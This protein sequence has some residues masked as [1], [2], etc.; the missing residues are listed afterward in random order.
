MITI[1]ASLKD[2]PKVWL[3]LHDVK[4]CDQPSF[5]ATLEGDWLKFVRTSNVQHG[6]M[7]VRVKET[8]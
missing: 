5:E 4:P 2:L 3:E 1:I 8:K 6:D 7:Y